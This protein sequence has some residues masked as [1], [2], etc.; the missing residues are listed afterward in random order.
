MAKKA[1]AA[2][3]AV[4]APAGTTLQVSD[5]EDGITKDMSKGQMMAA[6]VTRSAM[7]AQTLKAY[8]GSG[9]AVELA[10]YISELR[11]A[12]DE[13]VTGNM[14][15]VERMLVNQAIALDTVFNQLAQRASRAEYIKTHESYLRLAFKAQA[16]ARSTVEAIAL[17]KNPQ[18]YIRQANIAQGGNQQVNNMYAPT[19]E[20]TGGEKTE[21]APSKVLEAK[22]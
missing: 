10:D 16:Q 17:L 12:G 8:A 1:A 22:V 5:G 6:V 4:K 3:V 14:G 18:P 13:V 19:S 20:H 9:A 2:Q 11:R 21:V 15:R 7:S